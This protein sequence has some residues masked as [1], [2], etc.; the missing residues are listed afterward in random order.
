MLDLLDSH[1]IKQEGKKEEVERGTQI[2]QARAECPVAA[3]VEFG[4]RRD[5]VHHRLL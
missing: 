4:V 3:K 1:G 2:T 5:S